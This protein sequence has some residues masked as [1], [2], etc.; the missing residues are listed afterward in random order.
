MADHARL[1]VLLS[2]EGTYP[3]HRGGVSTWCDAL[4]HKLSEVD[5]TLLAVTMH[6]Y[7]TPQYELAPNVRDL[8]TVPLWGTEDPAEYGRH[9]TFADYLQRKWS[10]TVRDTEQGYVPAYEQFLR[11][12]VRPTLPRRSLGLVVL[13][14]HQHLRRFDYHRT[15]THR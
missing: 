10:T 8:I 4:T 12:M 13:R 11:E 14:L 6:P 9:A 7:L 5:F 2:T 15:H 3:Y 1:S